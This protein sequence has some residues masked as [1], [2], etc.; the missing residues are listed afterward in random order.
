M[1]E[2][3]A[4]KFGGKWIT[5]K[6]ELIDKLIIPDP[7]LA[8][9]NKNYQNLI[10]NF[11]H[12]IDLKI[13]ELLAILTKVIDEKETNI[14]ENGIQ[15]KKKTYIDKP[16]SYEDMNSIIKQAKS[17]ILDILIEINK[18]YML[19]ASMRFVTSQEIVEKEELKQKLSNFTC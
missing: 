5:D 6:K 3:E 9:Y 11:R 2:D 4:N 15:T 7:S 16:I 14:L 13:E 18:V 1:W 12:N 10:V 8:D 19:L 17:K